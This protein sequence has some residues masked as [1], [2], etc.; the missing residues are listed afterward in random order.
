[1]DRRDHNVAQIRRYLHAAEMSQKGTAPSFFNMEADKEK[2]GP[3]SPI[4]AKGYE[5]IHSL[6]PVQ[7]DP[8]EESRRKLSARKISHALEHV[9]RGQARLWAALLRVQNDPGAIRR[10]EAALQ[11]DPGDEGERAFL[12]HHREAIEEAAD[13]IEAVWPG[14]RLFVPLKQEDEPQRTLLHAANAEK[15]RDRRDEAR[16]RYEPMAREIRAIREAEGV[17]TDAAIEAYRDRLARHNKEDVSART[18]YRALSFTKPAR[19]RA[20]PVDENQKEDIA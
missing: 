1:M 7:A 5:Q 13:F 17:G 12:R 10:A 11:D 16:K 9:R 2:P 6:T 14:T 19:E 3:T 8:V 4:S 15:N 18:C 20:G